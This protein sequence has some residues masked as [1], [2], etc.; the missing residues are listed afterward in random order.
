MQSSEIIELPPR[1]KIVTWLH[2]VPAKIADTLG[3]GELF[4]VQV[5]NEINK[6]TVYI[7][8]EYFNVPNDHENM[9]LSS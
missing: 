5:M 7:I 3:L 4:V 6:K 9:H 2:S 1:G 8:S